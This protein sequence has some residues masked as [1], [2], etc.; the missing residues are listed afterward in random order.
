MGWDEELSAAFGLLLGRSLADYDPAATYAVYYGGDVLNE[1][2]PPAD[3]LS[4]VALADPTPRPLP[5]PVYLDEDHQEYAWH[6]DLS[7][8][9]VHFD[10]EVL[11]GPFSGAF[12]DDV[13]AAAI[14]N[15]VD[16]LIRGA[17]LSP[18]LIRH[19]IDLTAE[20]LGD[21]HYSI[22]VTLRLATDGTLLDALRAAT[23]THRGPAHLIPMGGDDGYVEEAEPQWEK[24]LRPIQ[25]QAL[26]D[27][28]RFH[29]VGDA[30]AVSAGAQYL[31]T[32]EWPPGSG[33]VE[34]LGAT[35]IAGWSFGEY[36]HGAAVVRFP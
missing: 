15:G 20:D 7:N 31:A 8:S 17:D 32:A 10:E 9:F 16:L 13:R 2:A 28:L 19:G 4:P 6:F 25:N 23:F 11:D 21:F 34:D 18:L 5:D 29:C 22:T 24:A 30:D 3:W 36:Q 12:A 27:H 26:R 35:L 1:M 14:L 33:A